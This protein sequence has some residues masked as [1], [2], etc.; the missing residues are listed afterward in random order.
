MPAWVV[1]KA[2]QYARDHALTPFII[3]QGL[4]NIMDR[5]FEREILPMVRSE[6]D[7]HRLLSVPVFTIFF[8]RLGMALAP[9]NVLAGGKF[10][11]DAEEER[12]EKTVDRGRDGFNGVDWRRTEDEKKVS[13]ALEKVAGELGAKHITSGMLTLWHV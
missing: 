6:G 13:K 8:L 9:W 2:N 11:T 7:F 3:Y 4:W 1:A 12:R 5:S 10:R